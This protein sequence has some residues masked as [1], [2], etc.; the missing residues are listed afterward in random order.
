VFVDGCDPQIKVTVEL[1]NKLGENC[2]VKN[3]VFSNLTP[4]QEELLK[5]IKEKVNIMLS[6]DLYKIGAESKLDFQSLIDQETDLD[7][8][9]IVM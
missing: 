2:P 5:P 4:A 9:A 3:I 6:S 8:I 7:K 1:I